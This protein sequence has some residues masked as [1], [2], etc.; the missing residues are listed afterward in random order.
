MANTRTVRTRLRSPGDLSEEMLEAL[1][2]LTEP[3]AASVGSDDSEL[4]T[5]VAGL[6]RTN[7][8]MWRCEDQIRSTDI[9]DGEFVLLKRSIDVLNLD[10][11][12]QTEALDGYV[13]A[14]LPEL[15][16]SVE[17]ELHTETVGMIV[18]RLSILALRIGK[19][20]GGDPLVLKAVRLQYVDLR[21]AMYALLDRLASGERRMYIYRAYKMYGGT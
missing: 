3:P 10:R 5:L 9:D 13:L 8:E 19:V 15:V 18:D 21:D 1:R 14:R 12:R 4:T 7:S 2:Q 11:H 6:Y 16:A 20:A 17:V